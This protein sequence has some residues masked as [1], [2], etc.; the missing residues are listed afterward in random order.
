M[1]DFMNNC[2]SLLY[3]LYKFKITK[4]PIR[5]K[6]QPGR[7]W[8]IENYFQSPKNLHAIPLEQ[9]VM[10]QKMPPIRAAFSMSVFIKSYCCLKP[11][12]FAWHHLFSDRV[13]TRQYF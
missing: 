2:K 10:K 13:S 3:N 11:E 12:R 4:K 5:E 6:T 9:S 8:N 7:S 1:Y